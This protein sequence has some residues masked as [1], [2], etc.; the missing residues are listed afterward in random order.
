[1]VQSR[2]GDIHDVQM[3]DTTNRSLCAT[4]YKVRRRGTG[5]TV[6]VEVMLLVVSLPT[7]SCTYRF[8]W[9]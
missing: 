9:L 3:G 6:Y 7:P 2:F 1:M 4:M 8:D 5:S